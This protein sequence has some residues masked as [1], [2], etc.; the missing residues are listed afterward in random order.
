LLFPGVAFFLPLIGGIIGDVVLGRYKAIL[1][2]TVMEF[3]GMVILLIFAVLVYVDNTGG[4]EF[5]IPVSREIS[6]LTLN[7][8]FRGPVAVKRPVQTRSV[9]AF[10]THLAFSSC[11]WID[12]RKGKQ[13]SSLSSSL[14]FIKT[15]TIPLCGGSHNLDILRLHAKPIGDLGADWSSIEVQCAGPP[16]CGSALGTHQFNPELWVP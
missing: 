13:R 10:K 8:R 2:G 3:F 11:R 7:T 14:S 9:D 4:P 6:I 12:R 15:P 16:A 1:Y 5:S